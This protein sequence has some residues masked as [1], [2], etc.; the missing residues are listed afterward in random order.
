MSP[1]FSLSTS[2]SVYS[3]ILH[4]TRI[5]HHPYTLTLVRLYRSKI[6]DTSR[7]ALSTMGL[8]VRFAEFVRWY[9]RGM[10][11]EERRLIF[12]VDWLVLAFACL[13]FFTK[14]LDVSALS[15]SEPNLLPVWTV[16][17]IAISTRQCLCLWDEGRPAFDR[18]QTKL[19]QRSL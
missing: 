18:K 3:V 4:S 7:F 2:L 13:S 14:Y 15:T 11:A 9:P 17:L 6:F 5:E 16:R 10:S 12:K 1:S 19:H 8:I